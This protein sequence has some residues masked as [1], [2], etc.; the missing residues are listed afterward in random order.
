VIRILGSGALALCVIALIAASVYLK[1]APPPEENRYVGSRTCE[2]CH[3]S[4]FA[5]WHDSQH[6]KMMRP[7]RNPG[8]LVANFGAADAPFPLERAYWAIGGKWEQQFMGRDDS[9]ETL[10]PGAWQVATQSWQTVGWDGWNKPIPKQRCH[11]CHT[12]GLDPESGRFVE[13]NVGCESCHGP[14]EWHAKTLGLGHIESISDAEVCGQCHSRGTDTTGHFQFPVGYRPG[15]NLQKYFS[16]DGAT[17]GQSSKDWWGDG[18]ARSR[19]EEFPDWSN[20]G[21]SDSLRS[22]REGYDGRFGAVTDACLR[23]HSADYILAAGAK[24][25]VE[26]ARDGVTCSVCHNVHGKLDQGRSTCADCHGSGAYYHDEAGRNARHVPCP[27]TAN[28]TCVDCHMPKIVSIGGAM[29]F[30]S[31]AAGIIQPREAARFDMP[32]SCSQGGCHSGV[33]LS[34]LQ[35]RYEAF[36]STSQ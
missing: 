14:G 28:V 33:D 13:A 29:Q 10:L 8:V 5:A 20:G 32:S 31:H 23:C 30:H 16:F 11:G 18:R 7:V 27:P 21:H 2:G 22:L 15:R 1:T 3:R 34:E 25:G 9:G 6:T 19:H 26:S 4:E 35:A 12:V 36:Y 24:P 17:D